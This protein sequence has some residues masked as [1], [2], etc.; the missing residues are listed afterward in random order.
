MIIGGNEAVLHKSLVYKKG[1]FQSGNPQY[2]EIRLKARKEEKL[3]FCHKTLN[4]ISRDSDMPN[5]RL[6]N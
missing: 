6:L 3:K 4:F 5:I 1:S 2:E